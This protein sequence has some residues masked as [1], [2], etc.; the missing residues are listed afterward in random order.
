MYSPYL[1]GLLLS[2]TMQ[3]AVI[4]P[5]GIPASGK[6]T[7]VTQQMNNAAPGTS[8]RINN[9][10]LAQMLYGV[11]F[12]F[13][14]D[15]TSQMLESLR[16]KML[17]SLLKNPEIEV[18]FLDNTNLSVSALRR[19]EA[20]AQ[21]HGAVFAVN[22]EFLA[23]PLAVALERNARRDTP[24]PGNV[25]QDMHKQAV[26][27]RAWNFPRLPDIQPYHNN[28]GLP[29]T[30]V[31][32]IDGT[33]AI[34]S[35]ER[36]IHDYTQV[37]LDSPNTPVVRLVNMFIDKGHHVTIMSGRSEDCR[38]VTEQWLA[39]HLGPDLPL[40]MRPSRDHRPD[41]IIKYE[42]FQQHVANRFHVRFVLDDRDQVITLWRDR[43]QL[44]T[45]QVAH[46]DF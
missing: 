4:A 42:L 27:L 37:H 15:A 46:G 25:I 28:L 3:K 5:R 43:L 18:V 40:H 14:S 41:W 34:K 21:Q 13:R 7:W 2:M 33:L 30:I 12:G 32:D 22:D 20:V 39:K 26:K 17:T 1:Y 31:V 44:P 11:P 35:P 6:T 24:V 9:D 29:S 45:F 8:A 16:K 38:D 19:L 36:D 10:D 23:T